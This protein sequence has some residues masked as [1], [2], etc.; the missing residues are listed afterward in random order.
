MHA[1]FLQAVYC[2]RWKFFRLK[3][4]KTF[5]LYQDNN[6]S[7]YLSFKFFSGLNSLKSPHHSL[8]SDASGIR[9]TGFTT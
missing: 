8:S 5:C 4:L 7:P 2:Q 6:K 9:D 3:P 1:S